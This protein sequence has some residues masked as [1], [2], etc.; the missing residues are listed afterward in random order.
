MSKEF[1]TAK[2]TKHDFKKELKHLYS[3]SAQ[4]VGRLKFPQ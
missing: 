2:Q 4:Q 3:P 1:E